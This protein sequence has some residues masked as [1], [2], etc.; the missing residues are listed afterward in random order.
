[1]AEDFLAQA[2]LAALEGFERA[3]VPQKR[4][5]FEDFL[6]R[7]R[8]KEEI[9]Q[10]TEAKSRLQKERETLLEGSVPVFDENGEI[11][12][13]SRRRPFQTKAPKETE[14]KEKSGFSDLDIQQAAKKAGE[15]EKAKLEVRKEAKKGDAEKALK[16][17]LNDYD[18]AI[19]LATKVKNEVGSSTFFAQKI[20]FTKSRSIAGNLAT[21]KTKIGF[22]ALTRMRQQSPTGGAL[23]QVSEKEG[24][25][26]QGSEFPLDLDLP[27]DDL[28]SNLN[29]LIKG[30]EKSKQNL[31]NA[32]KEDYGIGLSRENLALP[33]VETKSTEIN[34]YLKQL[35][36]GSE[37]IGFEE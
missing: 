10:E 26:L 25:W 24:A 29:D 2:A 18:K 1:M 12:G 9:A 34:K 11:I 3:Y 36:A 23:G 19:N 31:L 5:E 13:Y 27:L 16:E 33:S 17:V 15:V 4:L 32:Y 14:T 8:K 37:F 35:P 28:K 22:N 7:R 30:Y 21:L 6:A 20:P